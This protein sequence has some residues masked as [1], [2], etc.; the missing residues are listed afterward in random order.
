MCPPTSHPAP[1]SCFNWIDKKCNYSRWLNFDCV[2]QR[3]VYSTGAGASASSGIKAASSW[4]ALQQPPS[5]QAL[6]RAGSGAGASSL[7]RQQL[8]FPGLPGTYFASRP[9]G[10]GSP[11]GGSPLRAKAQ[12]S[13]LGA[14]RPGS[15]AA[16]QWAGASPSSP[17]V[18]LGAPG[19]PLIGARRPGSGRY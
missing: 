16:R 10:G 12:Y 18:L 1:R 2:E 11:S 17:T 9:A 3:A 19:S 15:P 5:P 4:R 7:P 13:P 8:H 6:L 14:R